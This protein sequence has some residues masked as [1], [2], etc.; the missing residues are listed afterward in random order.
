METPLDWPMAAVVAACCAV[1]MLCLPSIVQVAPSLLRCMARARES[2]H[3]YNSS[4]LRRSR[5]I[6]CAGLMP[7]FLL[8]CSCF[9]VLPFTIWSDRWEALGW[10][11]VTFA[12][13][14][15]LRLL[16]RLVFAHRLPDRFCRECAREVPY[17]FF[18]TAAFICILTGLVCLL[19]DVGPEKSG[20]VIQWE[21]GVLYMLGVIRKTQIFIQH[22]G[23]VAGIL[24]L[25]TLEFLPTG[26][27]IASA[28]YL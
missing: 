7:A 17:T 23:I 13:Y 28:M 19:A 16:C 3:L 8:I 24:Y 1:L 14:L 2:E 12:A 25:C 27:L 10:T 9:R 22:R 26:M 18:A 21:I 5:N 6:A 15:A 11:V 20:R 4:S